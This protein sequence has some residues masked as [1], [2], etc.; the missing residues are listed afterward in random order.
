MTPDQ[1]RAH[2]EYSDQLRKGRSLE[3]LAGGLLVQ[4]LRKEADGDRRA[5]ATARQMAEEYAAEALTIEH[6]C[7]GWR[8]ANGY[9]E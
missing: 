6:W 1:L 2:Q 4:A 3:S 7:A 8:A 5:A 9:D